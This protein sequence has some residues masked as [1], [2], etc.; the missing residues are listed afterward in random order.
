MRGAPLLAALLAAC[1]LPDPGPRVRVAE[2]APSGDGV[3][4]AA[5]ATIR[6]TGAVAADGLVDG[7]RCLLATEDGLRDALAAVETEEG[8][9][10]GVARVA[11]EL[12]L[13]EEGTRLT[14]RPAAPLAAGGAYALVL[15]SLA[16][17]L[18]GRPV[19]DA[20]GKAL[21]TVV[22][23]SVA[24]APPPAV[25]LTEVLADAAT[26]EAGGEYAEVLDLGPGPLDLAGWRFEKRLESGSWSGCTIGAGWGGPAPVGAVALVVGGSWDGR[27]PLP[28][29]AAV[30]PCGATSLAGGIANDRPPVIRLLDPSGA[31]ATV[32]DASGVGACAG[33]LEAS[34][35]EAGGGEAGCCS[36]TE[37]SPGLIPPLSPTG[38]EG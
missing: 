4:P 36:C 35:P 33:A 7:R 21:P 5:V 31:V 15:S 16:T 10:A 8:A 9:G 2:V 32:L 20:E 37:G 12:G 3:D 17:A 18:D 13:D 27:Y 34:L 23:F 25:I 11:A 29:G 30:F 14:L 38:G 26:P 22:R 24:R 1:A 6:F 28:A 19:L